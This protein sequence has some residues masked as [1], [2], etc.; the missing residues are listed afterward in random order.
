MSKK[1]RI[2]TRDSE[3]ALWQTHWV[4]K[5]L[6]ELN[7]AITIEI[8]EVKTIGDKILDT[9]LSKIGDK[10][11][12]TKEID[13]ALLDNEIDLAVHSMKDVPTTI[14]EELTI[15]AI[16]GRWHANDIL[17]SRDNLTIDTLPEGASIATGSLRRKAQLLNYRKDF[18][19]IDLRG[20]LNTRFRKFD[21]ADW[22]GM[23][24]AQAGVERLGWQ[25]RISERIS[26]N[27]LLPAVGQGSFAIICRE[28]DRDTKN[29]LKPLHDDHSAAGIRAERALLHKLEGGC[30]VPIGAYGEIV[31][32]RLRLKACVSSLDGQTLI[33]D[34]AEGAINLPEELGISV[35]EKLISM[36]GKE[37]LDRIIMEN[38]A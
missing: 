2:G 24:L 13:R 4:R 27:I 11:L 19:I 3:L 37:I 21:E 5:K 15:A 17:I 20:N 36:G 33:E 30:Q 32:N 9:P 25:D 38:R 28:N 22:D 26:L 31:Q 10:G 29:L 14:P 8:I 1:V 16:T 7:P 12:F 23:V 6:K 35:A 34:M 18:R